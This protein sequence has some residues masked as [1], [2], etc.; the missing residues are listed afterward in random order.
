MP[1]MDEDTVKAVSDA[2]TLFL[3]DDLRRRRNNKTKTVSIRAD[4]ITAVRELIKY[5][6]GDAID[7]FEAAKYIDA[8]ESLLKEIEKGGGK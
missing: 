1:N 6:R 8:V 2:V 3:E 4:F 7:A 5:L